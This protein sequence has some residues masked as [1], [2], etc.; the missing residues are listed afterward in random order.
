MEVSEAIRRRRAYRSLKPFKVTDE[1]IKDLAFHASLAPSCMNNQP[2]R[3]VF[4][5]SN[6]VLNELFST[7]PKGNQWVKN[8]SLVI[9]VFTRKDFDCVLEDN[10]E[11]HLFDTGLACAF[12]ILRAT[13]LN[14]V[15][16]PIAGYDP[17]R[18]K[19]I[20]NIPPDAVLIALIAV[21]E[22]SEEISPL[23]S[24]K[25]ISAEKIRPDRLPFEKFSFIDKYT[26]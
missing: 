17:V 10:R 22:H 16:H 25:Q 26:V 23:L 7:L 18:V 11:Y 1:L 12:L 14:L 24:E 19:E 5:V 15:A 21:G 3:F 9:A 4:V 2:W 8:S 13:E 6:E 20:L